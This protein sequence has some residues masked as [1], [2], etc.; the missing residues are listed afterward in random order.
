MKKK[1]F[2]PQAFSDEVYMAPHER[3]KAQQLVKPEMLHMDDKQLE[4]VKTVVLLTMKQVAALFQ[5][6]EAYLF[7]QIGL[8]FFPK[9]LKIKRMIRFRLT[10][11]EAF[12]ANCLADK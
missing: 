8:G 12:I 7:K 2:V 11:L 5:C 6:S 9:P 10:D 3:Q 1:K 4:Q